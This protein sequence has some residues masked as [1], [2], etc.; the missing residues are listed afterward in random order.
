MDFLPVL[1]YG[2]GIMLHSAF[3]AAVSWLYS[4]ADQHA[5]PAEPDLKYPLESG[6]SQASQHQTITDKQSIVAEPT[7]RLIKPP[8]G[9]KK[10]STQPK[11]Q[12][13]PAK[14]L[15][16]IDARNKA[17]YQAM[18]RLLEQGA[19]SDADL[20]QAVTSLTGDEFL[21]VLCFQ[22][23]Q[24]SFAHLAVLL[25]LPSAELACSSFAV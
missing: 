20:L 17:V 25:Q 14:A 18:E 19:F 12:G 4:V 1:S 6:K 13:K 10:S 9:L 22:Q 7:N 11:K 3:A 5:A 2:A 23:A 16:A 24:T 21:Q 15:N 8:T